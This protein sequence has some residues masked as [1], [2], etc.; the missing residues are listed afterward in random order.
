M[1]RQTKLKWRG[2]R[3]AWLRLAL[4]VTLGAMSAEWLCGQQPTALSLREAVQQAWAH[5][6]TVNEARA[7]IQVAASEI[8]VQRD[9]Y[10][11]HAS[12]HAE[13]NRATRNNVLGMM[14]PNQTITPI[15]GFA[16]SGESWQSAFGTSVGMFIRWEAYDFGSRRAR[17]LAAEAR[18]KAAEARLESVRYELADRVADAYFLALATAR[19]ES[20]AVATVERWRTTQVA[21]DA[22]VN[23]GLRPGADAARIRVEMVR[24]ET[25]LIQNRQHTRQRLAELG[26]YLGKPETFVVHLDD[27]LTATL[28]TVDAADRSE[29]LHPLVQLRAAERS[30]V[31]ADV[32]ATEKEWLPKVELFSA[33]NGRGSG[34]RIDGTFRG[35]LEGLYPDIGNWAAGVGITVNLFERKRA[36]TRTEVLSAHVDAAASRQSETELQLRTLAEQARLH[37]QAAREI[38]LKTPVA[39]VATQELE[40]QS[41]VRYRA[42]LG[43]ITEI[44]EAQR[45]LR[46]AE[47]EDAIARIQVWRASFALAAASGTLTQFLESHR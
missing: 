46:Q 24:A 21:V 22:L 42:G 8:R 17:V 20:A 29:A 35:G 23:A 6:P 38:V 12:F 40:N 18:E 36:R 34:A 41:Q 47:V 5:Y 7:G 19:A 1:N 25:E 26:R 16:L 43:D 28:P 3:R 33:A 13:A 39:L 14:M 44:A 30:A 45:A 2:A 27:A 11:P 10:L 15:N 37:L 31:S 32:K 9:A 4:T